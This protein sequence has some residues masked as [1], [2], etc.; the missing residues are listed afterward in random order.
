MIS[1]YGNYSE[2]QVNAGEKQKTFWVVGKILDKQVG[3]CGKTQ[4]LPPYTNH[5]RN[6]C[7]YQ[8]SGALT[9]S[10]TSKKIWMNFWFV[11][12]LTARV[13]CPERLHL[14]TF[15]M[16][17][18]GGGCIWQCNFLKPTIQQSQ[19]LYTAINLFHTLHYIFASHSRK[20]TGLTHCLTGLLGHLMSLNQ[21]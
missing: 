1:L 6:P 5:P 14:H 16:L 15:L 21:H 7:Y 9:F 20:S 8:H 19:P 17:E 3:I 11:S 12:N 13:S 10:F 4:G 18:L 2:Q